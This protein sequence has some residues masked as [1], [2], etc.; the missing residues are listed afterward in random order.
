[1]IAPHFFN[2]VHLQKT[3]ASGCTLQNDPC[4]YPLSRLCHLQVLNEPLP[5]FGSI[6]LV[7]SQVITMYKIFFLLQ[8][9]V[10][11]YFNGR[12]VTSN[13]KFS[14]FFP[15]HV[16]IVQFNIFYF[17]FLDILSWFFNWVQLVEKVIAFIIWKLVWLIS[18]PCTYPNLPHPR[19]FKG[20][21]IVWWARK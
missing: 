7:F 21:N 11:S 10:L 5:T 13:F 18:P 12:N 19:N 20:K 3:P 8:V 6:H 16:F 2:E 4:K 17:L 15:H 14:F 9:W 1:M